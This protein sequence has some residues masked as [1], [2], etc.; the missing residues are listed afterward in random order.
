[1][2]INDINKLLNSS[3]LSSLLEPE[4]LSKL[5]EICKIKKYNKSVKLYSK[6]EK[7][8]D[9]L[10]LISG[11]CELIDSNKKVIRVLK[12]NDLAWSACFLILQKIM[13]W[14]QYLML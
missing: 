5:A 2:E 10:M 14:F 7:V 12:K 11:E 4:V 6:G 9:F 3:E 13:I 8:T 1:M